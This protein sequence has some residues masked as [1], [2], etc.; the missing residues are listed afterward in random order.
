MDLIEQVVVSTKIKPLNTIN[1]ICI[2]LNLIYDF[3]KGLRDV[4]NEPQT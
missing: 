4:L 1:I 2:N 3:N